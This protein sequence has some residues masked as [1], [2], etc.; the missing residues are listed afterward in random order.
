MRKN[1][2]QYIKPRNQQPIV[3]K[4][5]EANER[6]QTVSLEPQREKANIYGRLVDHELE[7]EVDDILEHGKLK[8][9]KAASKESEAE[10][11]YHHTHATTEEHAKH[12][13]RTNELIQDQ[14]HGMQAFGRPLTLQL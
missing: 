5:K 9:V 12:I 3:E 6:R 11:G 4:P 13:K 7:K 8:I 2:H 10:H 1:Y 14:I